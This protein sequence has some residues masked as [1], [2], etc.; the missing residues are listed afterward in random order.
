MPQITGANSI[1]GFPDQKTTSHLVAL[2]IVGCE[3]RCGVVIALKSSHPL[4]DA[5]ALTTF[6]NDWVAVHR[7]LVPNL[8]L[9]N[10]NPVFSPAALDEA[11]SGDIDAR[12]PDPEILKLRTSWRFIDTTGGHPETGPL[13]PNHRK[14]PPHLASIADTLELGPPLPRKEWYLQAP[15][16]SYLLHF[17]AEELTRIWTA[18]PSLGKTI[19]RFDAL[20]AHVWAA[21]IP[22]RLYFALGLRDRVVPP[23]AAQSLASPIVLARAS[24]TSKTSLPQL[25][26]TIRGTLT[27]FTPHRVG[28]LQYE[29]AFD[30]D[31][32]R[33]WAEF[34]GRRNVILT[35]WLRLGLYEI[36]FGAGRPRF[37][38][39]IIPAT[40]GL[41]Q[42]MEVGPARSSAGG[43][44]Y[45]QGS[46]V[47]LTLAT[48][49][50]E[51][52]VKDPL[53]RKY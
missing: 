6:V 34:I 7:A 22:F 39:G 47:S 13:L 18:E 12:S 48:E 11:A 33:M 43:A 19:S 4:S 14:I 30:V 53:F 26:R 49:V 41:M 10:L 52:M 29:M 32:R 42:V 16:S 23:L 46:S 35:S 27:P 24:A 28:A 51:R 15:V 36:D 21:L 5:Q 3:C 37:V 45:R 44:W 50:I 20:Q 8:P 38:H 9:P 40:D 31:A 1:R 2:S 17:S 25:A